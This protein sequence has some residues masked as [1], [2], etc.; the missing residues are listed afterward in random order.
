MSS[1]SA[2]S[3]EGVARRFLHGPHADYDAKP[4]QEEQGVTVVKTHQDS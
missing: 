1:L 2:L 4:T 3:L